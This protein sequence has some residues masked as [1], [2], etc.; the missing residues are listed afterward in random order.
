AI[1][2]RNTTTINQTFTY[3]TS[4]LNANTEYY[5]TLDHGSYVDNTGTQLYR[6]ITNT[7][8][9]KFKTKPLVDSQAP[10][11][12]SVLPANNATN[13]ARNEKLVLTFNEQVYANSGD[14]L[15][16]DY[17][18]NITYRSISV[19]SSRVTGAGTNTITIDPHQQVGSA[20]SEALK[21]Y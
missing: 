14:I 16:K 9:W 7:T 17:I 6:G 18:T 19:T 4:M 1:A 12:T 15:I 21:S 2:V 10:V 3:T 5:I 13:V 8:T 11:I 20:S